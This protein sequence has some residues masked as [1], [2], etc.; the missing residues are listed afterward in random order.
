MMINK[1]TKGMLT[2]VCCALLASTSQ[3]SAADVTFDRLRSPE[4]RNWLMNHGDYNAH[5]FSTLDK[6]NKTNV[7]N[8]R[9]AFSVALGQK[10]GNENLLATPLVEDGFIYLT[11]AWGMLYKIDVRSGT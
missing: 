2:G 8:L 7:K 1:T 4:P 11:D 6:I 10:G 9:F 5:R 3:L